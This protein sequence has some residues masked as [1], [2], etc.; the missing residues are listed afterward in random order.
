MGTSFLRR[1][2]DGMQECA[3]VIKPRVERLKGDEDY[4][5]FVIKHNKSQVEDVMACND[6]M[7]HPH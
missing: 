4:D 3:N 5:C 1:H 2:D 7:N 6:I